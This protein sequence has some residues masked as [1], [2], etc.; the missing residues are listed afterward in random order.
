MAALATTSS[1]SNYPR[2]TIAQYRDQLRQSRTASSIDLAYSYRGKPYRYSV[3]LTTTAPHYGGSRYWLRCPSCSK[4]VS[5]LYCAGAYVCRGCIGACYASQLQQPIDRLFSRADAI[6]QRLGWQRGIAYGNQGRPKG[7]H[8]TTYY[9]LVTE[10]D[11]IVQRI[12]GA[13]M[14][15]IDKIKGSVSYE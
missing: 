6:R 9:R 12:C 10:H 15:M 11:R 13:T 2:L 1:L 5:V 8:F 3:Q 7:M 14:Q 4:R